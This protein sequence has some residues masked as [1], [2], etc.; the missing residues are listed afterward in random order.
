MRLKLRRLPHDPAGPVK[1]TCS[2]GSP[3]SVTDTGISTF[4]FA[5]APSNSAMF[6]KK[7]TWQKGMAPG[8]PGLESTRDLAEEIPTR[9]S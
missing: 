6:C 8:Q 1:P 7:E 2:P 4:V 9:R 5:C 3:T